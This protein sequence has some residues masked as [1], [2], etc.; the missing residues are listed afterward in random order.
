LCEQY[1]WQALFANQK[2]YNF[3]ILTLSAFIAFHT[4]IWLLYESHIL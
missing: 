2:Q 4:T 1:L 3:K